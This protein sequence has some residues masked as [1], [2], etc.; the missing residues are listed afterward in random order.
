MHP[1]ERLRDDALREIQGARDEKS[2]EAVRVKYL[3]KAAASP[4]GA[5][6]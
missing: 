4:N 6:G 2:L 5:S 1:L 3:G